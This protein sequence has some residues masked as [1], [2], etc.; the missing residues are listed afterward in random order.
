MFSGY[1]RPV[2]ACQGFPAIGRFAGI[3]GIENSGFRIEKVFTAAA[4]A[5]WRME[6]SK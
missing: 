4:A 2:Q 1:T 6:N 5:E 3:A